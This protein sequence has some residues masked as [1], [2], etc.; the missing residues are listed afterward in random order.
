LEKKG[1]SKNNGDN[2]IIDYN[3]VDKVLIKIFSFLSHSVMWN[4]YDNPNNAYFNGKKITKQKLKE[5]ILPETEI[6]K[7]LIVSVHRYDE[8]TEVINLGFDELSYE[9]LFNILYKYYNKEKID[10]KFIKK[11]PDDIDYYK[12]IAINKIK[13][14]EKVYRINLIGT[15]CRFENVKHI[16]KNI[17]KLILGS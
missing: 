16:S 5:I 6:N 13:L 8:F 3:N 2:L 12:E 1:G 9:D 17:Y 14:G 7:L 15:L 11:I 4:M 10:L